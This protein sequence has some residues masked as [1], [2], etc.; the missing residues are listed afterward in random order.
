MKV[1]RI[2]H[3]LLVGILKEMTLLYDMFPPNQVQC[4]L[5]NSRYLINLIERMN[6]LVHSLVPWWGMPSSSFYSKRAL[7]W[8][9]DWF[10]FDCCLVTM[11]SCS[12]PVFCYSLYFSMLFSLRLI[13]PLFLYVLKAY[14]PHNDKVS[15]PNDS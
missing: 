1:C 2:W 14:M 10:L 11:F 13:F 5:A 6:K 9:G 15:L 7:Y 3:S 4:V 8:T 12:L